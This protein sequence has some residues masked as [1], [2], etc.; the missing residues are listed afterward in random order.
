M[1][2]YLV[3]YHTH[4]RHALEQF[5][6]VTALEAEGLNSIPDGIIVFYIDTVL[7][8]PQWSWDRLNL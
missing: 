5:V 7:P 8:T 1:S 2:K 6:R 3:P 4:A